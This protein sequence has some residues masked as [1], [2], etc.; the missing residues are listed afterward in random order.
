[1]NAA[2]TFLTSQAGPPLPEKALET[3]SDWAH[4]SVQHPLHRT[5]GIVSGS[6]SISG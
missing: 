3:S 6:L 4:S 5:D 2:H 1:M